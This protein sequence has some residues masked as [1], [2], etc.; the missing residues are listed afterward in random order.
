MILNLMPFSRNNWQTLECL[1]IKYIFKGRDEKVRTRKNVLDGLYVLVHAGRF[2][3]CTTT[4]TIILTKIINKH[5]IFLFTV[6]SQTLEYKT[7]WLVLELKSTSLHCQF[8]KVKYI[9][10]Q[11]AFPFPFSFLPPKKKDNKHLIRPGKEWTQHGWDRESVRQDFLHL[12]PVSTGQSLKT[13]VF[14]HLLGWK[15]L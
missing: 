11:K 4:C 15:D 2:T 14:T 7:E 3:M 10:T 5:I 6:N 13:A 8:D 12:S 9:K 1:L